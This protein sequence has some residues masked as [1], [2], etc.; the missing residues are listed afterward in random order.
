MS[1]VAPAGPMYQAGTL[2]GNPV[3][4]T[5]GLWALKN[6]KPAMLRDLARR[7]VLLARDLPMPPA[8]P[9]SPLQVNAFGSLL[10]PFFTATPVRHCRSALASNTR[11]YAAFFPGMLKRGVYPPPSQFGRGFCQRLTPTRTSEDDCGRDGSDERR[12]TAGRS[13][14]VNCARA[15]ALR[16]AYP[17]EIVVDDGHHQHHQHHERGSIFSLTRMLK[18]RRAMPSN[19]IIGV[20]AIEHRH[21]HQVQ[22]AEVDAQ[23]R[24]QREQRDE[25]LLRRL[26]GE[27]GNSDRTW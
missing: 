18:S 13:N 16:P 21:R 11:A 6:L 12:E 10:T 26:A 7:S 3:A 27:L 19:A 4:M 25:A 20:A 8:T 2:S 17:G 24:H 23:H 1:A 9:R 14:G 22:N 15:W 5:A